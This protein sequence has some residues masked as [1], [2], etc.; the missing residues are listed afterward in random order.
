LGYHCIKYLLNK[1]LDDFVTLLSYFYY[2]YP[3]RI[4]IN[5]DFP[6]PT[7]ETK[8]RCEVQHHFSYKNC[9]LLIMF[10]NIRLERSEKE[11]N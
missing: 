6:A 3:A 5:V 1:I 9:L 11:Q 10:R 7:R 8:L 4:L 2:L